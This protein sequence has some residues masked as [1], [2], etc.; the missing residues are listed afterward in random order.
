MVRAKIISTG[1]Y[2]PAK[3]VTND[4]LSKIVDTS[5]EWIY[6]RTGIRARHMAEG[7]ETTS[8]MATQ[9]AKQAIERAGLTPNDIDLIIVGT[10][11]PDSSFPGV[12]TQVQGAL[13]MTRGAGFDL[14]AACSGF[15][16]GLK[17][18]DTLI[19]S[20]SEKTIL[21]IGA[22]RFTHMVDWT[23][24]STC[25]L[26]GDGAGAVILQA[27]EGDSGILDTAIYSD[28]SKNDLL[29]ASGGIATTKTVGT[30]VMHG[31]EVFKHA[32]R[33]MAQIVDDLLS[34]NNLA[35]T[36]VTWLVPHQANKRIIDATAKMLELPADKVVLTV[37]EHANTSAASIPLA[38][39]F[40]AEKGTFKAGD[41][42]LFEAFGAGFTWGGA[43]VR[44]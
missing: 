10:A 22:E 23:D 30:V 28:G 17:L 44:W 14:Q 9:A 41:L 20:G 40:A 29:Y 31:R 4:D 1:G 32:T 38:L 19:R 21:V 43:L 11:T 39:N 5:D 16:Y 15:V 27:S 26:F 25:V 18:A 36:D 12:S 33:A 42:L 3:R 13:G 34:R 7:Q 35:R 24:R 2:L 6:E 8:Y 37:Q